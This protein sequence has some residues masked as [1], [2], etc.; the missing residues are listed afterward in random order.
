M[1][2]HSRITYGQSHQYQYQL[3]RNANCS[4][5]DARIGVYD[6]SRSNTIQSISNENWYKMRR[7]I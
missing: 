1:V 6:R 2:R 7:P 5:R 3:K 4:E